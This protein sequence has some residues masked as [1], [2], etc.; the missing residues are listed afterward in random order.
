LRAALAL[1]IYVGLIVG[2]FSLVANKRRDYGDFYSLNES[3]LGTH[4]DAWFCWSMCWCLGQLP[5][6]RRHST[7]V[8]APSMGAILA[9]TGAKRVLAFS[10]ACRDSMPDRRHLA[11]KTA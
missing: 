6:G 7:W 5:L 2:I 1:P 3:Y 8:V 11:S 4:T 10:G 9:T